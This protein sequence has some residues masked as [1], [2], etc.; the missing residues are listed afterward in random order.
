MSDTFMNRAFSHATIGKSF[1]LG[2]ALL[3]G[4]V[5]P[6]VAGSCP[7]EPPPVF[8]VIEQYGPEIIDHSK[9][10]DF[11]N[12]LLNNGV[13]WS[14]P[15]DGKKMANGNYEWKRIGLTKSDFLVATSAD[16]K[17]VNL[18]DGTFCGYLSKIRMTTGYKEQRIY[19]PREFQE[20][21]CAYQAILAHERQHVSINTQTL[22]EYVPQVRRDGA[23][24]A[25][26]LK[27]VQSSNSSSLQAMLKKQF[28]GIDL[29]LFESMRK[30]QDERNNAIDTSESYSALQQQCPDW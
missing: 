23:K 6:A 29:S 16:A 14:G 8:E 22:K 12:G 4:G 9:S 2:C 3:I 5:L 18:P 25:E 15:S 7:T 28:N 11:I 19:I 30:T 10:K 13:P 20:G 27:G 1:L 26:Q 21:S 17:I 24:K